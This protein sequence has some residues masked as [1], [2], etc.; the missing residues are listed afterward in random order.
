MALY[1]KEEKANFSCMNVVPCELTYEKYFTSKFWIL[2]HVF[3]FINTIFEFCSRILFSVQISHVNLEWDN[4]KYLFL[5]FLK[6]GFHKD[7]EVR[8]IR[9]SKRE[10]HI[11]NR[12]NKTKKEVKNPDLRTERES[13]QEVL[14]EESHT[15]CNQ[16]I[17]HDKS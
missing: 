12:L 5:I 8:K 13:R 15:I 1:K 4:S 17:M 9:V 7:K 11:V 6:V 14:R 10:N 16:N 2:K 3:F